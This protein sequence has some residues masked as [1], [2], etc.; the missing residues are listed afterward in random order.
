MILFESLQY[1]ALV[2]ARCWVV[3]IEVV[4][5]VGAVKSCRLLELRVLINS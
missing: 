2:A 5:E 4:L 3:V 1:K